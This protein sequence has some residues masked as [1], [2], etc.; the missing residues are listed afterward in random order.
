M[1]SF[2]FKFVSFFNFKFV[3]LATL[4]QLESAENSTTYVLFLVYSL[5]NIAVFSHMS[6]FYLYH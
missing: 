2:N 1:R 4:G 3:S 6:I 5:Q